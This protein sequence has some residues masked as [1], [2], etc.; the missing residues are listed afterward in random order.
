MKCFPAHQKNRPFFLSIRQLAHQFIYLKNAMKS[1]ERYTGM[2]DEV[3]S[4]LFQVNI[5]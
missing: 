4:E 3:K 5:E 1:S 2:V